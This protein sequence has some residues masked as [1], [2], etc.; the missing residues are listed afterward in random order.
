MKKLLIIALLC[1]STWGFSQ[2]E[3]AL[4]GEVKLFAGNYAPQGWAFCDGSLLT[5]MDNSA[6]FAVLGTTYGGDGRY[7]FALPDLR[8]SAPSG[9]ANSSS[10]GSEETQQTLELKDGQYQASTVKNG[11]KYIICIRGIFPKRN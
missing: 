11:L 5:I 9:I 8:A 4:L 10:S 7:N 1:I 2:T 6:L 3:D